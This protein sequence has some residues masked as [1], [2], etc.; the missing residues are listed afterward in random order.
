MWDL[1]FPVTL[2][3]LRRQGIDGGWHATEKVSRL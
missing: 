1:L 3:E 2:V